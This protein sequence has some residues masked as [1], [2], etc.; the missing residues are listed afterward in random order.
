MALDGVVY[1][2][3]DDPY[4][5]E[6]YDEADEY[7]AEADGELAL[8]I[9]LESSLVQVGEGGVGCVRGRRVCADGGAWEGGLKLRRVVAKP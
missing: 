5:T 2:V 6:G 3:D 1:R 4:E 9:A 8:A 7:E